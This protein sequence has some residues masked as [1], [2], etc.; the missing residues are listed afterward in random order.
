M[1]LFGRWHY[2][3]VE[4][5]MAALNTSATD[6]RVRVD[7]GTDGEDGGH[8]AGKVGG[9]SSRVALEGSAP[10]PRML[11][12]AGATIEAAMAPRPWSQLNVLHALLGGLAVLSGR[13]LALPAWNCTRTVEVHDNFLRPGMLPNRCFWHVHS[14]SGVAC[15]FR[16]G[17]CGEAMDSMG[18]GKGEATELGDGES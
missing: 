11:A 4:A 7:G 5:E 10:R 17:G 6:A 16:I 13:A 3:A 18:S 15:V 12:L 9:G 8:I 14:K 1:Q 2:A